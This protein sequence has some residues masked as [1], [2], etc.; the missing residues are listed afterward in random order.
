[1]NNRLTITVL[2]LVTMLS[3]CSEQL[4]FPSRATAPGVREAMDT[5]L[6]VSAKVQDNS[7]AG[8]Q[9]RA[10]SPAADL[11]FSPVDHLGLTLSYNGVTNRKSNDD[12]DIAVYNGHRFD[13]GAGY[14]SNFGRLGFFEMYGGV[15]GGYISLNGQPDHAFTTHY[16]HAYLQPAAG[17][18]NQKFMITGG[19]RIMYQYYYN[20]E[21]SNPD[22][23]Y[24]ITSNQGQR[25]GNINGSSFLMIE[26]F[27][28]MEVGYKY[29]KFNLQTGFS[30]Q[31]AGEGNITG[32]SLPAY[33]SLGIVFNYAPRFSKDDP[34][35]RKK[36]IKYR[37]GDE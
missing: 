23:P 36:R 14:Y 37:K 8:N 4:Y 11:A 27:I 15:G 28:N 35:G 12:N 21:S 3:S 20:F 18:G 26:P 22:L 34:S 19:I 24:T 25:L 31:A 9:S 10:I 33:M 30:G 6:V 29:I 1:M 17:V 7:G 2:S 5:K 13:G 32:S 16:T